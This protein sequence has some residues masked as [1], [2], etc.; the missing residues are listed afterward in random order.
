MEYQHEHDKNVVLV[1]YHPNRT[2]VAGYFDEEDGLIY[3]DAKRS[4]LVRETVYFHEITHKE[5]FQAKCKC[6][7]KKTSFLCEYHAFRGALQCVRATGSRKLQRCYLREVQKALKKYKA[8]LKIWDSHLKALRKI[9]KTK[10]YRELVICI[11]HGG[12]YNG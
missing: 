7:N 9:M 6:W 2:N 12:R 11:R 3:L 4:R 10:A 5:C 1:T 8:D